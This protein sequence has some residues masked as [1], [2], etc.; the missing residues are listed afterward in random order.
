ML[1]LKRED[2]VGVGSYVLRDTQLVKLS[3]MVPLCSILASVGVHVA[4]GNARD[5][6]FFISEADYPGLERFVFTTGLLTSSVFHLLLT[7]RL[8][9]VFKEKARRKTLLTA[10]I[11]GIT[12]STHLAVL[13]FANM[14]DHL[15]LHVYTSLVVFHGGFTW[16]ILAHFSLS[17]PNKTGRQL[18]LISLLAAFVSLVTMTVAM[19]RGIEQQRRVLEVQPDMIPLDDLQP[20]IDVAAPAEFILFFSL[21]GC[22]ASFSWDIAEHADQFEDSSIKA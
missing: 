9:A 1:D 12:S 5:V 16:A 17:H 20:W 2:G 4:L 10:T 14:Y 8:Y 15:S 18:R 19:S 11:L 13:S 7:T 22:L 3:W 21:L 6:P